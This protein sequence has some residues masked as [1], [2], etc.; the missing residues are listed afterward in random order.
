[1]INVIVYKKGTKSPVARFDAGSQMK[2]WVKENKY[3]IFHLY[4]W[5]DE[6]VGECWVCII[7]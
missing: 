5:A 1:M 7:K 6:E 4:S 2:E 3:E